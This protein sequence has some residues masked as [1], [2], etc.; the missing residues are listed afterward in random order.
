MSFNSTTMYYM[1]AGITEFPVINQK[2]VEA[3]LTG[4]LIATER[5]LFVVQNKLQGNGLIKGPQLNLEIGDFQ[6]R[7]TIHCTGKCTLICTKNFDQN[8]F[9][10]A[11]GGNFEIIIKAPAAKKE[12]AKVEELTNEMG[13]TSL[14]EPAPAAQPA[15]PPAAASSQEAKPAL[16]LLLITQLL[17]YQMQSRPPPVLLQTRT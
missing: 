1:N 3:N 12:V 17:R 7:G 10:R 8:M 13:N 11:G 15:Q 14:N 5:M 16:Q 2:C 4:Q 9:T 6:F